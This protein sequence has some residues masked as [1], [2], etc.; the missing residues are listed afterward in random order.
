MTSARTPEEPDATRRMPPV[1]EEETFSSSAHRPPPSWD[2]GAAPEDATPDDYATRPYPAPPPAEPYPMHA[3]A[4]PYS[5]PAGE[6][7]QGAYP[8]QYEQTRTPRRR[9]GGCFGVLLTLCLAVWASIGTVLVLSVWA[10][11]SVGTGWAQ[12]VQSTVIDV[13]SDAP[14]FAESL[15]SVPLFLAAGA[16]SVVAAFLLPNAIGAVRGVGVL[17][18][19]GGVGAYAGAIIVGLRDF[20]GQTVS[21]WQSF[22]ELWPGVEIADVILVPLF[23]LA[24]LVCILATRPRRR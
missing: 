3:P 11:A 8:P 15:M 7:D 17:L 4:G 2:D 21:R 24:A 10:Q 22:G 18:M 14:G 19:L 13:V 9:S 1:S 5:M 23:F 6:P 16:L 20:T 12:A